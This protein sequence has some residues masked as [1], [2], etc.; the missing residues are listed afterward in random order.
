MCTNLENQDDQMPAATMCPSSL[1]RGGRCSD[2]KQVLGTERGERLLHPSPCVIHEFGFWARCRL[3]QDSE[4][5]GLMAAHMCLSVLENLWGTGEIHKGEKTDF[6]HCRLVTPKQDC[7][8]D[9]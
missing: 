1:P 5:T 6:D 7:Q 3:C 2:R 8:V 9:Y 4:Q